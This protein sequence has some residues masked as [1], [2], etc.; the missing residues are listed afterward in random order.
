MRKLISFAALGLICLPAWAAVEVFATVPEWGA[1]TREIGG[2]KVNVYIATTAF[3]DPHRIDARPSLLA[4][5][6]RAQLVPP[7]PPARPVL[8]AL[9]GQR[10]PRA[11]QAHQ[12]PLV[13]RVR[14]AQ[15]APQGLQGLPG[16][17]ALQ[18]AA[19]S[20]SA[21]GPPTPQARQTAV[22]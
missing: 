11:L 9:P 5:A 8:R 19:R 14:P 4:R 18:E 7:A 17:R 1:L 10:E 20:R 21:S 22:K 16:R 13:R 6:R 15:R 3:Q 2:D 12:V